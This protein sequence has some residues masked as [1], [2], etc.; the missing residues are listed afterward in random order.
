MI[1]QAF[2]KTMRKQMITKWQQ[3]KLNMNPQ[4]SNKI[5][6]KKN[7]KMNGMNQTGHKM[8]MDRI[9]KM[10]KKMLKMKVMDNKNQK[11]MK[12][13]IQ[14]KEQKIPCLLIIK[15]LSK[16]KILSKQNHLKMKIKKS[17]KRKYLNY[18][19]KIIIEII[20]INNKIS[21]KTILQAINK[22]QCLKDNYSR[23][24]H[25]RIKLMHMEIC[26][27]ALRRIW[28]CLK[29]QI[30]IGKIKAINNLNKLNLN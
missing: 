13:K 19:I 2:K 29:K 27:R 10:K 25:N 30:V 9:I 17:L 15:K 8:I 1:F 5:M 23:H 24:L 22:T 11:N 7:R 26:T 4:K 20:N 21:K 18:R 28:A 6:I 3:I 12:I 14:M 16:S